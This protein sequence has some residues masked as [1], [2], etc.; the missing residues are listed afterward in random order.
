MAS[1]MDRG[2]AAGAL[3]GALRDEG[4]LRHRARTVPVASVPSPPA[5]GGS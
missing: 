2:A 1:M 4:G 3:V 5:G